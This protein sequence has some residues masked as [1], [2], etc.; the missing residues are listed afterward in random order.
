MI[1]TTINIIL[2]V[3]GLV[4]FIWAKSIDNGENFD[5]VVI[6]LFGCILAGVGGISSVIKWIL[7]TN[8]ALGMGREPN[9]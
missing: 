4:C 2:I 7:L 5:S 3:G 1:W 6:F 9:G 8:N